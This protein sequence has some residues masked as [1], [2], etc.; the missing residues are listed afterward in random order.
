MLLVYLAAAWSAGIA[1]AFL[2][3][4]PPEFWDVGLLLPLGLLL[5]WRND[6][7]LRRVH[8]CVL[9][10]LLGALRYTIAQPVF[11]EHALAS[12]NDRGAVVLIGQVSDPPEKR[13]STT[14]VHVAVT[15]AQVNADWRDLS[16]IALVQVP[17]ETDVRYGDV[18]RIYGAP[19]TPPEYPDFSYKDYLARQGIHSLVQYASLTVQAHDQGDWFFTKLYAFRDRAL[20]AIY[21][22]LP[23]PAASLLAG[24]LL[25]VDSGIPSDVSDAFS[26]TNTAHIIAI[27][28]QN[29][30]QTA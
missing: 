6:P 15:R 14:S 20:A 10:L 28:G 25:G 27:S 19:T 29:R 26:A 4:F 21:A 16:G 1:L 3:P 8:L 7:L 13:D 17:R 9:F 18:V 11:D 22:S 23:D 2:F 5:I 24:I 30:T 12:L